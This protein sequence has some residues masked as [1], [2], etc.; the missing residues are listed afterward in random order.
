MWTARLGVSLT[1]SKPLA[2]LL[3]GEISRSLPWEGFFGATRSELNPKVAQLN[4]DVLTERE[5]AQASNSR[6]KR[7]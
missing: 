2:I 3:L 5:V 4:Y 1:E 6:S 7:L